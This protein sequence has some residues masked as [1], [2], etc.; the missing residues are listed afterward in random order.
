M[1]IPFLLARHIDSVRQALNGMKLSAFDQAID[2]FITAKMEHR[3][4]WLVGNGGSAATAAHFA[5]DLHKMCGMDVRALPSEI[6]TILAYG[7]DNGWVNMFSDAMEPF[8]RGDVLVAISSSGSSPNVI[9]AVRK[10]KSLGGKVIALTGMDHDRN[11]LA[12][13]AE[14]VFSVQSRS[15]LIH[16]DIHL[17]ICHAIAGTLNEMSRL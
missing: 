10:A 9:N 7:N 11:E 3:R 14:V 12:Q 5:N 15:M 1:N 17:I 2:V 13:L 6:P 16:E 4:V 8:E